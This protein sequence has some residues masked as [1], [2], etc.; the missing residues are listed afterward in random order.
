MTATLEERIA[1]G[2]RALVQAGLAGEDAALDAEVLAR[3]V[4]GW[5]RTALLT[6]GR[7]P[8]SPA[9]IAEYDRAVSRRAARE[10]VALITG[11]REFWGLD[12][13]VTRDVLIPRPETELIVETALS[14][15]TPARCRK[16]VDVGTGSGCLAVALATELPSVRVL[17]TDLSI[18]ALEVARRNARRHGVAN[19]VSFARADLLSAV[20]GPV[21]L[22]V[23]NPPYCP[24][25]AELPA[26]VAEYEPASALFAGPDGLAPL[27]EL[28]GA[29]GSRLAPDGAF[30]VEFG[31]GQADAIRALALAAGWQRVELKDDLQG[32]P[33]IAVLL[34]A[35]RSALAGPG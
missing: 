4:L 34:G 21:D 33:R 5:D 12:F 15:V 32:I 18:A 8:A 9:F 31:F 14:I 24:D 28:I 7:E 35:R 6:R 19:R 3:H 11:H 27:R 10:P 20:R 29:A 23:S 22:I 1:N 2:R 25:D 30:I 26:D 16:I 13:E 17:A